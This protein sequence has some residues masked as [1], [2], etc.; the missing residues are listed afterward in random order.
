[1]TVRQITCGTNLLFTGRNEV[2][3]KV[4]FLQVCVCPQGGGGCLPQ[5]MLGCHTPPGPGRPPGTIQTPP[6]PGR[7]PPPGSRLQHTVYERPVRILLECILVLRLLMDVILV[8]DPDWSICSTFL[9]GNRFARLPG[10]SKCP[11]YNPILR[12][13]FKL[14]WNRQKIE[15]HFLTLVRPWDKCILPWQSRPLKQA[16]V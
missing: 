16:S 15:F 9:N 1:M 14:S 10:S 8:C 5:C 13:C 6:G 2:V 12:F 3:A 7:P 11:Q 4:M